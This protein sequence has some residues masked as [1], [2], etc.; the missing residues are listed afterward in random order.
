VLVFFLVIIVVGVSNTY[1]MIVRERVREIGTLRAIGM[2][3][4]AVRSLFLW[5]AVLLA[6]TGIGGGLLLGLVFL[7]GATLLDLSNYGALL[8]FLKQGRPDWYLDPV[9]MLVSVAVMFTSCFLGVW[10]PASSA[11]RMRPVDALNDNG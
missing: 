5:E 6:L 7:F 11:A 4:R 2:Q 8:M 1:R 10:R 9:W 3:A